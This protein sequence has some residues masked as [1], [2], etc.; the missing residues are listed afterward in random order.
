MMDMSD[1]QLE[2][3]SGALFGAVALI[4]SLFAGI[5]TGNG[6]GQV[7]GRSLVLM[8]VFAALGYIAIYVIRKYVPEVFEL[9][10]A[11]SSRRMGDEG[12]K[13]LPDEDRPTPAADT[14]S[15]A[16]EPDSVAGAQEPAGGAPAQPDAFVPLQEG[17]FTAYSSAK[18]EQGKLG[19]HFFEQKNIRYEPKIMAEAIRTMIARDKE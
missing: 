18:P 11:M 4:I 10:S 2:Y 15:D 5:I 1:I 13:E 7:I 19:K 17:D 16:A 6:A 14:A 3:R 12:L 8:I 9:L